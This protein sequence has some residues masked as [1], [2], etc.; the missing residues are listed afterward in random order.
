MSTIIK[1]NTQGQT[2]EEILQQ[3]INVGM[4]RARDIIDQVRAT[5]PTDTVVPTRKL[6]F[7]VGDVDEANASDHLELRA[8]AGGQDWGLHRNALSQLCTYSSFPIRYADHL[9][10]AGEHRQRRMKR[11]AYC[12]N[13]EMEERAADKRLLRSIG[14]E[15][16]GFLSDKYKRID[17]VKI[18]DTFSG[19]MKDIN[20]RPY[21]DAASGLGAYS[22]D[23]RWSITGVLPQVFR[24]NT[25]ALAVGIQLRNSDFGRGRLELSMYL[26]RLWCLNGATAR[27]VMKKTHIGS[28]L[29]ENIE[30]SRRTY[31]LDTA[32][33]VSALKDAIS[34]VMGEKKVEALVE[35]IK[36]LE[37]QK[38]DWAHARAQ[39]KKKLL[40]GEMEKVEAAFES[41]D[42]VNLPAGSSPWRVSNAL[43]W[44]AKSDDVSPDR[45]LDLERLAGDV[46][47]VDGWLKAS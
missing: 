4:D 15:V 39:L 5:V 8:V 44:V 46:L 36:R 18:I 14:G 22:T 28:R 3:S 43:S 6:R 10:A 17:S 21:A 19:A 32:T 26:I 38:V 30:Y 47:D 1:T 11:L 16:R 25:D 29:D 34:D 42:I 27:D 37:S 12:L 45:K 31:E 33:S 40:K 2:A 7:E 23:L 13:Q 41:D 20:A 9:A 24:T 35:G